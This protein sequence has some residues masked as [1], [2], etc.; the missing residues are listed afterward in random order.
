[1]SVIL[2][3][4]LVVDLA[5][6]LALLAG[7][8][9][10]PVL[11]LF[12]WQGLLAGQVVAR[13]HVTAIAA[14]DHA[15]WIARSGRVIAARRSA[16][17]SG[18]LALSLAERE[19]TIE[20]VAALDP[21]DPLSADRVAALRR[22]DLWLSG[23]V[24]VLG[25][26]ALALAHALLLVLLRVGA[27]LAGPTA[28]AGLGAL[29]ADLPVVGALLAAFGAPVASP[30]SWIPL[31]A[32]AIAALAATFAALRH[33]PSPG[34]DE[35]PAT[36]LGALGL[37]AFAPLVAALPALA[38]GGRALLLPVL[39]ARALLDARRSRLPSPS[40]AA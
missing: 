11:W 25:A 35:A 20:R 17:R 13:R 15:T 29:L 1:M 3:A 39:V 30:A 19:R 34:E 14:L 6:A 33:P 37:A 12:W 18:N 38:P 5:A 32:G 31:A 2:A 4:A 27:E 28:L 36:S 7:G 40:P 22:D 26:G 9:A 10:Y 21:G 8:D 24:V 16:D 23:S